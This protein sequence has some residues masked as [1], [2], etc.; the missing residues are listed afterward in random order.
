LDDPIAAEDLCTWLELLMDF[1]GTG[2]LQIKAIIN[3][4]GWPGPVLLHGAQNMFSAPLS[5]TGWPTA[6]RRTRIALVT[7]NLNEEC[8]G[9]LLGILT[10]ASAHGRPQTPA[11]QPQ[12]D[13][14]AG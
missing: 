10:A 6:D 4:A 11:I 9:E 1:A 7:R 14:A 2:L 8:L 3:V 12:L 5:L 13:R